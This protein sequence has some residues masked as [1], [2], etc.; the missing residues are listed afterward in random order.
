MI[1]RPLLFALL[2]APSFLIGQAKVEA[3]PLQLAK[4]AAND[5]RIDDMWA[6]LDRATKTAGKENDAAVTQQLRDFV[7]TLEPLLLA[8]NLRQ[9]P[10]SERVAALLKPARSNERRGKATTR[11]ELLAREPRANQLLRHAARHNASPARRLT[12]LAALDRRGEPGNQRFVIRTAIVDRSKLV[13]RDVL[14]I[15]RLKATKQH[16]HYLA[17]G[18]QHASGK[19]RKRTADALGGL[20][21]PAAIG[22]L[23]KAGPH[24]ATG[25]AGGSDGTTTRGHVAFLT[26]TSYVRDFDVEV[27]SAAFIADPKVDVLQAGAVLDATVMG[28]TNVRSIRHAYRRALRKLTQQDPGRDPSQWAKKLQKQLA[29]TTP[30]VTGG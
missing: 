17:A 14:K 15:V 12:A 26:Q 2:A 10:T 11:I 18:L 1:K 30:P 4:L 19:V 3:S 22:L 20:G 25:L 5:E 28:V 9:A 24:A 8:D 16:V 6:Q 29:A 23:V 13:R 27:A 21:H 7:A